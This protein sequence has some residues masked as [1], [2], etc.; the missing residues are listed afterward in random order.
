M[1]KAGSDISDNVEG[2][3]FHVLRIMRTMKDQEE[4]LTRIKY[5]RFI[6]KE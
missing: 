2:V 6:E 5:S 3:S 4:T 1:N